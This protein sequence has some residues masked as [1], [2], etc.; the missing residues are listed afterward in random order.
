MVVSA[1]S[2]LP[3]GPEK[4][5]GGHCAAVG[6]LG[7]ALSLHPH[8]HQPLTDG[9]HAIEDALDYGGKDDPQC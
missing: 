1:N 8:H 9:R 4:W 5:S 3:W 7:F 2:T 6:A